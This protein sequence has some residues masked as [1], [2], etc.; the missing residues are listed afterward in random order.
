MIKIDSRS[1]SAHRLAWLFSTGVWPTKALDHKDGNK[2]NNKLKNLRLATNSQNKQ[3]GRKYRTNKS[4]FKG[5]HWDNEAKKW[6]AQIRVLGKGKTLGRFVTKQK[7]RVA[8][9]KAARKHFG[10]FARF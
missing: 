9:S 2:A 1:Y 4:G 10:E 3:N 6:R 8:Y 5:V 7:A